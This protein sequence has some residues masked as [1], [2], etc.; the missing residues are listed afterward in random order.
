MKKLFI[1]VILLSL[2]ICTQAQQISVGA[3]L[4]LT[5]SFNKYSPEPSFYNPYP[6]DAHNEGWVVSLYS[7]K[8]WVLSLTTTRFSLSAGIRTFFY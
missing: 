2:Q 6:T 4:G 3:E 8:Q 1:V 5:R 7:K